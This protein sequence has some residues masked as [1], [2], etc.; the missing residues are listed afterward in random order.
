VSE[1]LAH[2]IG[3]NSKFFK[4]S[5]MFQQQKLSIDRVFGHALISSQ[6]QEELSGRGI[7]IE[8][9]TRNVLQHVNLEQLTV[10]ELGSVKSRI[11]TYQVHI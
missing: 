9:N 11:G 1:E 10:E 5:D 7:E 4:S 3:M 2:E 8:I 6:Y